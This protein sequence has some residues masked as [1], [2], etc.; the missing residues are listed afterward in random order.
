MKTFSTAMM[1]VLAVTVS[2]KAEDLLIKVANPVSTK[3]MAAYMQSQGPKT[4]A[5]TDQWIRVQGNVN[6]AQFQNTLESNA[7]V[8][9]QKNY[10]ASESFFTKRT[11][12]LPSSKP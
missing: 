6:Q 10:I 2:A 12:S 7:I 9:V 3:H 4:E 8:Y 5:L 1:L 11:G